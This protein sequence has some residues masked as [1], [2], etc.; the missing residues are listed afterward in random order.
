MSRT[1]RTIFVY[2]AVL[3]LVV[4]AIQLFVGDPNAPKDLRLEEFES[5]LAGGEIE[6]VTMKEKSNVLVGE[7]TTDAAAEI[8]RNTGGVRKGANP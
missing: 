6:N 4:M 3:L 2:I 8:A 1:A 5:L 7:F